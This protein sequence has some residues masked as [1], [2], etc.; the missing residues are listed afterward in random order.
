MCFRVSG[1]EL[2]ALLDARGGRLPEA[3]ACDVVTQVLRGL[4]YMH[5]HGIAHL[6]LKVR[7][8]CTK[9]LQYIS[10]I[11]NITAGECDGIWSGAALACQTYRLRVVSR[12]SRRWWTSSARHP[13]VPRSRGSQLWTTISSYRCLGCWCY[14]VSLV[15]FI[16]YVWAREEF[17]FWLYYWEIVIMFIFLI[18]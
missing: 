1:G 9:F 10:N 6:D 8:L 15:S 12:G 5:N 2:E 7:L 13:W 11:S 3:E 18:F 17:I 14:H 4:E 16:F